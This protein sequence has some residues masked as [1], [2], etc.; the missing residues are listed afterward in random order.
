MI[1]NSSVPAVSKK[2]VITLTVTIIVTVYWYLAQIINVYK[3]AWIGAIYEILWI[4]MVIALFGLPVFSLIHC[5]K[6]KFSPRS[7][8]LYSFLLSVITVLVLIIWFD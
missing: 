7:L 4:G 2:S 1:Q 8:Y 6:N 5:I 3:V